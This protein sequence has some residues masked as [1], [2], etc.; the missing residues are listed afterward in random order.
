MVTPIVVQKYGGSSVADV[1]RLRQ[2]AQQVCETRARG[3]LVVVVVSAMGDSTNRLLEQAH[4]I[5]PQPARRELDMLV[6][7]GERIS[8]ALLSMALH[9][10]GVEA[11]SLTGSQS[12]IL[13]N[14]RHFDA[15]IIEVRPVRIE[16][17]LARGKV[18]I[19][20]GYQGMSYKRE[21]T[22]LGR[23]GSDTT[24][25]ALAAALDAEACEIYTDVDGVFDA[26]P[27]VV[28]DAACLSEL[29]YEEMEEMARNGAR[30]L[31]AEAVEFARLHKIALYVKATK[32]GQGGTLVR[33]ELGQ[34]Q[35]VVR[36]TVSCLRALLW[37]HLRVPLAQH[38]ALLDALSARAL[39][40]LFLS[41][42][43]QE[44][45]FVLD[46]DGQPAFGSVTE[47]FGALALEAP[48]S[49]QAAAVSV[50]GP[51]VGKSLSLL[52][53]A[54]LALEDALQEPPLQVFAAPLR[55]T[56]LVHP[57]QADE[58][59]RTLYKS[60]QAWQQEQR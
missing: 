12:G 48:V 40:P 47:A 55:L 56:F 58:A 57:A 21:I 59:Q 25:V 31:H 1:D 9:E 28:L 4:E 45:D 52:Q 35:D 18:V 3:K 29:S 54:I 7:A 22:T 16:D 11:I 38:A 30:V 27:R 14:D 8:M 43:A 33:R 15:R 17:E 36:T 34:P 44:V 6:S 10:L 2:V 37:V 50:I 42:R 41:W 51:A 5:A 49:A 39:V 26:D 19:V 20:A 24:A 23:G 13:T 60:C 32:G 46:R 53:E